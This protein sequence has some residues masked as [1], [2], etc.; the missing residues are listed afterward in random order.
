MCKPLVIAYHLIWTVYGTWL[1]NDPRGSGSHV[2]SSDTLKNLGEVHHGR[3]PIQPAGQEIRDFYDQATP[4]LKHDVVR[5]TPE[6]IDVVGGALAESIAEANYTCWACAVMPDHLHVVMRK[7]R[8]RAEDMIEN[9]KDAARE[10]LSRKRLLPEG[11]PLWSGGGGW[12]V[13]LEHPD[14]VRRTIGYVERDPKRPQRWSY[15]TAY[16]GWP[17]HS[18]HSPH[19]PYA[20]A[21]RAAERYP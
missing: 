16:N 7:H 2:V 9:L 21:L 1:P 20:K 15:V 3:K 8:D 19:S 12:K 11:H 4:R 6:M 5:L 17:L 13:F 14:E 18:G 10:A